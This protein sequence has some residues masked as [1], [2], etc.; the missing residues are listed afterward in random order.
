MHFHRDVRA[1]FGPAHAQVES[2]VGFLHDQHIG[3]GW[4]ANLVSP[5]LVRAV[6]RIGPGVED[7]AIVVRPRDAVRGRFDDV[8]EIFAVVE[9]AH[10]H[11]EVLVARGVRGVDQ[12]SMARTHGE[13]GDI[14]ISMRGGEF[15]LVE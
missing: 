9:I 12:S 15:V 10:P 1:V 14:E 8:L 6:G 2:F 7:G 5:Q 11:R 4:S 13:I 3:V